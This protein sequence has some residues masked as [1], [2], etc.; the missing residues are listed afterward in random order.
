LAHG[1]EIQ[2]DA[3]ALSSKAIG[4]QLQKKDASLTVE[5]TVKAKDGF[6]HLFDMIR[7]AMSPFITDALFSH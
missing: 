7:Q 4:A 5:Q 6:S 1:C 3:P 2:P